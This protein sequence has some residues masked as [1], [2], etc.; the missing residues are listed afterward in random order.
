MK[1]S[2][3]VQR[4][5]MDVPVSRFRAELKDWLERARGGEELVLTDHGVPIARVIGVGKE[6]ALERLTRD[7][8]ISRPPPGPR[9]DLSLDDLA[10]ASGLVS[11]YITEH[12]R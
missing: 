9:P 12:R 10:E 2:D 4:L 7:G 3:S 6:T 5:E 1:T 11:T 8:V